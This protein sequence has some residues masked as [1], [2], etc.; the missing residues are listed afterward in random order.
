M[1]TKVIANML[2]I[3]DEVTSHGLLNSIGF[4]FDVNMALILT[5]RY[6][7]KRR[8]LQTPNRG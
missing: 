8:A 2:F 5:I 4:I 1:Q 3:N 6:V 7:F